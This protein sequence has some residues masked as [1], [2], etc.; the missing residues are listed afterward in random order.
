MG[1]VIVLPDGW[2][3]A[4]QAAER[5]GLRSTRLVIRMARLAGVPVRRYLDVRSVRYRDLST[6]IEW[7]EWWY[8]RP[9]RRR[10]RQ[11]K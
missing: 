6:L 2:I 9:K 10:I 4:R 11:G 1:R 3:S 7:A 8:R 5:Y